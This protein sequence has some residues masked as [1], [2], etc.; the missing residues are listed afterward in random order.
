M[1]LSLL[2]VTQAAPCTAGGFARCPAAA[3]SGSI[4]ITPSVWLKKYLISA[5]DLHGH[6]TLTSTAN[7]I[8]HSNPQFLRPFYFVS[9]RANAQLLKEHLC[10]ADFA[11]QKAQKRFL[12]V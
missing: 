5:D 11:V 4:R 1:S 9:L 10:D 3:A 6:R 8:R 12:C 2:G 7:E